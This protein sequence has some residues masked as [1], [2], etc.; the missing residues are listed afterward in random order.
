MMMCL[1][2]CRGSFFIAK[3][4][5]TLPVEVIQVVLFSTIIY[6]MFGYQADAGK[7]FI[8]VTL[9]VLFALASETIGYICAIVTKDSKNG[10]ALITVLM[11]VLMSF[12]G[13]LVR[14]VPV[15]FRCVQPS[16]GQ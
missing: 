16:N 8:F 2:I 3:T 14:N 9:M 10:V 1:H 11:V 15:F 13:Y 6:W 7:Y 5:S 4:L 12:S